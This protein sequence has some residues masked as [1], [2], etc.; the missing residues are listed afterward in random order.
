MSR[1]VR[2]MAKRGQLAF[3]QV[4]GK[5][6]QVFPNTESI[7]SLGMQVCWNTGYGTMLEQV[8]R[9]RSEEFRLRQADRTQSTEGKALDGF[10]FSHTFKRITAASC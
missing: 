6:Q 10:S 4:P 5:S 1:T 9:W 7:K 2:T 3:Q 8:K